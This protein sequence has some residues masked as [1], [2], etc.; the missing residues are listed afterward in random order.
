MSIICALR[1]LRQRDQDFEAS[2]RYVASSRPAWSTSNTLKNNKKSGCYFYLFRDRVSLCN[3]PGCPGT[4]FVGQA[5]LELT[6]RPASASQGLGS[7]SLWVFFNW[8][9][10][11]RKKGP[12]WGWLHLITQ[13]PPS[14]PLGDRVYFQTVIPQYI[15]SQNLDTGNT[16]ENLLEYVLINIF[17]SEKTR[18]FGSMIAFSPMCTTF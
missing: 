15:S 16:P 10:K 8:Y 9:G 6:D 11:G 18:H 7:S 5:G 12:L 14:Q 1:R 17:I 4:C 2:F 13:M 3:S